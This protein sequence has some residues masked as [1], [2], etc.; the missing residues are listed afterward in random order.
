MIQPFEAEKKNCGC[1]QDPCITYGAD[2]DLT[3]TNHMNNS[4]GQVVPITNP[5]ELPTN[6]IETEAGGGPEGQITPDTFGAESWSETDQYTI[7]YLLGYNLNV[8]LTDRVREMVNDEDID[9][10]TL[11]WFL[12]NMEIPLG[13]KEEAL[14]IITEAKGAETFEAGTYLDVEGD[15]MD[16]LA[17]NGHWWSNDGITD[18]DLKAAG[19]TTKDDLKG[20][21]E[22]MAMKEEMWG[23]SAK[24]VATVILRKGWGAEE[25]FEAFQGNPEF[26]EKNYYGAEMPIYDINWDTDGD[27][28]PEDGEGNELPRTVMVPSDLEEDEIA[29]YLSD[30]YGWLVIG[31]VMGAEE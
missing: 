30:K 24:D 15:T 27:I 17:L 11:E 10:E 16:M 25:T 1:G 7:E 20:T 22:Y 18:A 6:L 12:N 28:I 21:L 26:E 23:D 13:D 3:P 14:E 29:D 2:T 31:F 4:I 19:L 9:L 5:M 8:S